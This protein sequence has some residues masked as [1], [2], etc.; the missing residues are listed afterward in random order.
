M[1]NPKFKS[2][3]A[4]I[5]IC[6]VWG[7]TYLAIRVGVE[8]LPPWLFAGFRW[9]AAGLFFMTILRLK[10]FKF[11]DKSELFP[12]MV[13]GVLLLGVANGLVV[14][15][16][17]WL[18]SG[19]TALLITTI[20]LI[21]TVIELIFTKGKSYNI[22]IVLGLLAG[23][24]GI[25]MIL[26]GSLD[27]IIEGDYIYGVIAIFFGVTAWSIG[28]VYSKYKKLKSHP[29]MSA[30]IQM[31][32]AGVLQTSLGFVLGE[33]ENFYFTPESLGAYLY[34]LFVG[35][36]FGYAAYIYAISELPVSFVATYAYINPVIALFVGW[37]FLDEVLTLNLITAAL[38]I[39]FGVFLVNRGNKKLKLK[40]VKNS[41]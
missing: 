29:L 34:L 41:T 9:T 15:A 30:A 13:V 31:F 22:F 18:P 40:I 37:L 27:D 1:N 2:Y 25:Y 7:T 16:E 17:Q 6:I 14:V 23:S 11:P 26:G 12:I 20:P 10:K 39:L 36:L 33:W 5:S 19:L 4:Y 8:D 32:T 38:V 35:S 3:L 24:L 28:S 21:I